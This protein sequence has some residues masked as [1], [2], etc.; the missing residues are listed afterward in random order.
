MA[1]ATPAPRTRLAKCQPPLP[2][3]SRRFQ[4]V[5]DLNAQFGPS[6]HNSVPTLVGD[7]QVSINVTLVGHRQVSINVGKAHYY[8][9]NVLWRIKYEPA[10]HESDVSTATPVMW[11]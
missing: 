1:T 8:N 2:P 11:G 5:V 4:E 9:T 10:R 6:P 7:R 3:C